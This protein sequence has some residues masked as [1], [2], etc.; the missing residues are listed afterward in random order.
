MSGGM[1][2]KIVLH[3]ASS[4][5]EKEILSSRWGS[6]RKLATAGDLLAAGFDYGRVAL[7]DTRKMTEEPL[8]TLVL[9]SEATCI[10]DMKWS[11]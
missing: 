2:R 10:F 1:S 3:D 7:Y 8:S 5:N 11:E 4:S 6:V 9:E